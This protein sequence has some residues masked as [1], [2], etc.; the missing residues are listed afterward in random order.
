MYPSFFLLRMLRVFRS[1]RTDD[2]SVNLLIESYIYIYIYSNVCN[3]ILYIQF[4]FCG[5]QLCFIHICGSLFQ[6]CEA[7]AVVAIWLYHIS[8]T[9][10]YHITV[11]L[12]MHLLLK[13]NHA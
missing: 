2:N 7:N 6:S 12:W 13:R 5:L 9:G 1:F 3:Y 10:T 11:Y 4:S 8:I